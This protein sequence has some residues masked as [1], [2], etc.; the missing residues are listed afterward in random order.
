MSGIKEPLFN[1]QSIVFSD[2]FINPDLPEPAFIDEKIYAWMMPID[3]KIVK[4]KQYWDY[5]NIEIT[6]K[7]IHKSDEK[8]LGKLK[9]SSTFKVSSGIPFSHKYEML[10][11]LIDATLAQLQG[12][13]ID[14]NKGNWL[15]K[16]VPQILFKAD[17]LSGPFKK[18]IYER[19]D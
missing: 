15:H 5:L 1:Y 16:F 13:W 14:K 18:R 9:V 3:F 8:L 11:I 2:F 19:W 10:K 7:L 12:G 17:E 4:R 6:L